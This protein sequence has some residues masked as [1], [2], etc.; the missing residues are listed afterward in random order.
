[1]TT[2]FLSGSRKIGRLNSKIRQRVQNITN[3]SFD[4]IVGDANGADKALQNYLYD[5]GYSNVT[6]YCSGNK[7]RNNLGDW[8]IKKV[9]VP[10]KLRGRRFYSQKDKAMASEADYGLVLWDGTSAGAIENVLELLKHGKKALV[11]F[12]PKK[13]FCTVSAAEDVREMIVQCDPKQVE[14][15][16]RKIGLHQTLEELGAEKQSQL[17]L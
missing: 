6:V 3:Q 11:Y 7:C 16:D 1:M 13:A 9:D 2:V 17:N 14:G 15:I 8:S 4:I 12:S 10:P 5:I